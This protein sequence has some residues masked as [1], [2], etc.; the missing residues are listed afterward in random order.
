VA[1]KD[2]ES[3][4]CRQ[5]NQ[6][7][8]ADQF[9]TKFDLQDLRQVWCCADSGSTFPAGQNRGRGKLEV[10]VNLPSVYILCI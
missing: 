3:S 5:A 4:F 9:G 10:R 6:L 8:P 7:E 1:G 2:W